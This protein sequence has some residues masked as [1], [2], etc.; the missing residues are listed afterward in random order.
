MVDAPHTDADVP[1]FWGG[2]GL[3]GLAD[4]HVHFMPGNVMAKVWDYFERILDPA[5]GGSAWPIRYRATD[6]ERVAHLRSLGVRAFSALSYPHRLDMAEWLNAWAA[7]FA[8]ATP[9]CLRSAT[10]FPEPGADRYVAAAVEAGTRVFKA[11]LQVGGYDPRDPLLAPVWARL[12]AGGVPVVVHCGSGPQAGAFTGP[13]PFG[14]VLAA[15]PSLR[16]VIAHMGAPE[17]GDFLDLAL[18]HEHVRLDTTMAFTPFMERLAPFPPE[19]VEVL[20]AHPER[21]LL[22][23]DFPNLP[24]DYARQLAALVRLGLG[25]DWLRAVCWGN[26]AAL[27]DLPLATG[28]GAEVRRVAAGAPGVVAAVSDALAWAASW[29]EDPPPPRDVAS[30]DHLRRYLDDLGRPGDAVVVAVTPDGE[31]VGAAWYRRFPPHEPGYGFVAQDVPELS[32][33]VR[34]GWRGAGVGTALLEGLVACARSEGAQRLSLSVEDGNPARLLYQRHG[35]VPYRDTGGALTMV[36]DLG[37]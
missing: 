4:V 33:A 9:G 15:H 35:F 14:E 11:H 36:T 20:G 6:V 27:F 13:G 17:Y 25:D 30:D 16:A 2:L 24:Y 32:V 28:G 26:A 31:V 21:V 12:A 29:R 10:F 7:G 37:G 5:T 22:G 3:P 1:A 23:S 18:R 34:P 19:L 8:D